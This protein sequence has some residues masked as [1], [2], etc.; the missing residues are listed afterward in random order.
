MWCR[1]RPIRPPSRRRA[2]RTAGE[3]STAFTLSPAISMSIFSSRRQDPNEVAQATVGCSIL[4]APMLVRGDIETEG[5]LRIDG[6]LEGSVL[7]ADV[8]VVGTDAVIVGDVQAR[9]VVVGGT[10]N[11]NIRASARVELRPAAKVEGDIDASVIC[12]HEGGTVRGRLSIQPIAGSERL[13]NGTHRPELAV[14]GA[15]G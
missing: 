14:V 1:R 13:S 15:E 12:I 4:D 3:T 7:N 5:S 10:V 6:R 2:S 9:E 11:G 8:L